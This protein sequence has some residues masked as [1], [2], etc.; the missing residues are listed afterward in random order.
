MIGCEQGPTKVSA[1]V[2][3]K[4]LT[5]LSVGKVDVCIPERNSGNRIAADLCCGHL[6]V[7]G[8]Q[9]E[10]VRLRDIL[11]QICNQVKNMSGHDGG[12]INVF[13]VK[14]HASVAKVA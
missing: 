2:L 9:L 10:Q 12:L 4:L 7:R 6:A 1:A 8:E 3:H 11:V 5:T 13:P 14:W